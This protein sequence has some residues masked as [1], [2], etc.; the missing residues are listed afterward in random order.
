MSGLPAHQFNRNELAGSLGDLGTLLPLTIALV[1]INSV[2]LATTLLVIGCFYAICGAYYRLPIPVQPLK[3][4]A[5]VAIAAQ[6]P[7]ETIAA[8][9][10]ILGVILL[11][12][13]VTGAI[14]L[15]ARVFTH[16]IVRGIQLGLGM[17]L[18]IKGVELV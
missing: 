3:V 11:M 15:V 6:L 16:P 9:G 12:L 13:A 18:M 2:P 4:V 10:L 1:L 5:A 17:I 7:V 14:D 8:S